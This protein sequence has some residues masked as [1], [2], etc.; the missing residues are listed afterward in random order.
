MVSSNTWR[1]R[2]STTIH[3]DHCWYTIDALFLLCVAALF[4]DLR[5]VQAIVALGSEFLRSH[6]WLESLGGPAVLTTINYA[7]PTWCRS[8]LEVVAPKPTTNLGLARAAGNLMLGLKL[9]G[10]TSICPW[11]FFGV[12]TYPER[13]RS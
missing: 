2:Y 9:P 4:R 7:T 13:R 11:H 6:E 5:K 8:S 12:L 3:S 1:T 10:M